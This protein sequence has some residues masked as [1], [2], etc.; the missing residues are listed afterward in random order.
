MI[1]WNYLLAAA[2]ALLAFLLYHE[3]KRKNRA[4]VYVRL[5]ASLLSV[6]SLVLMAYPYAE[7]KLL[8]PKK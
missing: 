2:G 3:W 1:H 4:R 5:I 7:K 6:A 8:T